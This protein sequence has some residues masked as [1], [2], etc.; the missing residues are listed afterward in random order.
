M[1]HH[2][3]LKLEDISDNSTTSD[4]DGRRYYQKTY[5]LILKGY[6]L[7]EE[8]FKK[9]ASIDDINISVST[10]NVKTNRECIVT[11]IDLDCDLCFNFKFTRKS[12]NSKTYIIPTDVEF[13]YDNQNAS[14]DYDYFINNSLVELP[15]IATSG[16]EI[17]VAH[18]ITTAN[19][20]NIKICG[21]KI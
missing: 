12:G 8:D 4:L 21:K 11:E 17:T 7:R 3:P 14:N 15:F 20:V 13:Y 6:L 19:I 9:L 5:A 16:D 18:N 2:M 10:N 1:G